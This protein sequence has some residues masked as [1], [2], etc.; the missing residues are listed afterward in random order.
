MATAKP[1]LVIDLDG[2]LTPTDTLVES[3]IRLLKQSPAKIFMLFFLLLKG[4]S[5]FKGFV[6]ATT[7]FSVENLPFNEP[8]LAYLRGEKATVESWDTHQ[9]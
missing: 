4:R 9:K 7:N 6:A 8:F 2:T 1:P 3:V 5:A